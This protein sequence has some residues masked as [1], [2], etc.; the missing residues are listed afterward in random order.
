MKYKKWM[1]VGFLSAVLACCV[2]SVFS[3]EAG[4]QNSISEAGV[5]LKQLH[6]TNDA[7]AYS[8]AH[9]MRPVVDLLFGLAI[10]GAMLFS[11]FCSRLRDAIE[12]KVKQR[13]LHVPLYYLTIAAIAFCCCLPY[14]F[15]FSYWLPHH[16]GLSDMSMA[17]WFGERGKRFLVNATLSSLYWTL[18]FL[19]VQKFRKSWHWVLFGI[20]APLTAFMVFV[21]PVAIDPLFNHF[22]ELEPGDLRTR[23]EEQAAKAGIPDADVLVADMSRQTKELNAYVTGIGPTARIVLWDN[24]IKEMPE[25]ELVTVLGHETGHYVLLHVYKGFLLSMA[26]LL[27]GLLT[28]QRFAPSVLRRLPRSWGARDMTDL[29]LIPVVM[30][31][32]AP[33]I[34]ITSP[35]ECG[36][37]RMFEHEADAYALNL[38]H[39]HV[40]MA[41]AFITLASQDLINPD[42][43]EIIEF[44]FFSHP[45]LRKRISFALSTI[46]SAGENK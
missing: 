1:L 35:I 44:W 4:A 20:L 24:I 5:Q 26:A 38:T 12:V 2:I 45:S 3:V 36:I 16:Y 23:I 19:I 17:D 21:W 42:P 7:I 27:L 39:K 43:P 33:A 18:F 29:T 30:F 8:Q 15:F 32:S 25:N 37:S 14:I 46:P 13:M 9:Y 11:G 10:Y 6:V 22:K 34:F 28:A 31:F 40:S 41:N